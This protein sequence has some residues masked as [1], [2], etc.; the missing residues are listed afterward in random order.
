MNGP[1]NPAPEFPKRSELQRATICLWSDSLD[2]KVTYTT[3][4]TT[5]RKKLSYISHDYGCGCCIHLFDVEGPKKAFDALPNEFLA[6]STWT[7]RG[8][9]QPPPSIKRCPI[10]M[11]MHRH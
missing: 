2:E 8:I 5:W 7:E 6:Y 1:D 3:W 9:K 11:G 10:G 4:L